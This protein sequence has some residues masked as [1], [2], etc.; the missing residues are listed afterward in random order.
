[1]IVAVNGTAVHAHR[2]TQQ[3]QGR[4]IA[5]PVVRRSGR[6]AGS[7]QDE[8]ADPRN[9]RPD[10]QQPPGPV[11]IH[12]PPHPGRQEDDQQQDGQLRQAGRDFAI[13]LQLDQVQGQEHQHAI[14][15]GIQQQGQHAGD[16]ESAVPEQ[17]ATATWVA[18]LATR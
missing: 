8:I 1:M 9:R 4:E 6:D 5:V 2:H 11:T 7:R 13:V 18:E 12:D 3:N 15:T 10:D 16:T 14:K 17:A